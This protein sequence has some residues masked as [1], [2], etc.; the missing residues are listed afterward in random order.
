[1]STYTHTQSIADTTWTIN[2]QMG[3]RPIVSTQVTIDG[4]VQVILP[5]EV[6]Y[7]DLNNVIIRF[8]SARTGT[9]RL[10]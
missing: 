5:R 3:T 8:T 7:P 4:A 6:E 9:A 10:A 1:M 2:H